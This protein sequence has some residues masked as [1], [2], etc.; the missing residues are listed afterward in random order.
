MHFTQQA[1]ATDRDYLFHVFE[2]LQPL[3]GMGEIMP[4]AYLGRDR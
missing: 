4:R 2:Q 1:S 3:P